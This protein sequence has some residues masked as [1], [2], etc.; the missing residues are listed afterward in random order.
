MP[1]RTIRHVF[2]TTTEGQQ[3]MRGET[4][5]LSDEEAARGDSLGSFEVEEGQSLPEYSGGLSPHDGPMVGTQ[6]LQNNP[7]VQAYMANRPPGP[8]YDSVVLDPEVEREQLRARLAE[9]EAAD[10]DEEDEAV[11]PGP[12]PGDDL[13]DEEIDRLQGDELDRHVEAANIDATTGGSRADG[14]LSAEE[15]RQALKQHNAG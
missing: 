1:E 7:N 11:I 5:D 8:G 14:S 3:Y 6:D 4:V 12:E 15:K 10:E 13:T 9:L 2:Y